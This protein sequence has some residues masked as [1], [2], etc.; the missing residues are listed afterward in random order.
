MTTLQIRIKEETKQEAKKI[1]ETLGLD[2]SGAITIFLH[3]VILKKGIPFPVITENGFTPAFEQEVLKAEKSA[4][5]SPAFTNGKDAIAYLHKEEA[6]LS[7]K[8]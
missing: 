1:L 5:S 4:D 7:K 3:Q 2:M 6:K 8:K